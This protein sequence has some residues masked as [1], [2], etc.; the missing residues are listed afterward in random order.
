MENKTVHRVLFEFAE[1]GE[2]FFNS[3]GCNSILV[4]LEVQK[5][6]PG[7]FKLIKIEKENNLVT[8]CT[9]HRHTD[10]LDLTL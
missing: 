1:N 10:T 2:R 5:S 8:S 4:P 6:P 7:T 3:I 9:D